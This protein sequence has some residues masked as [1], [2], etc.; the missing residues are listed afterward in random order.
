M[1]RIVRVDELPTRTSGKVDRDALPWP[2]PGG[3]DTEGTPELGGTARW[4][5]GLWQDLLGAT[6][7]GS[8]A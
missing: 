4:L 8:G 2:P 7:T 5:A 1:P 6:V 3:T